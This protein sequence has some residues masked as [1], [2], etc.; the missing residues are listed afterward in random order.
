MMFKVDFARQPLLFAC[1]RI[2]L[3]GV[4]LTACK[5]GKTAP[6]EPPPPQVTVVT[7]HAKPVSL[8]SEL[9]GRTTAFETAAIEPQVSGVIRKRLFVEG[10]DVEVGQ[11]LY[12][13]DPA[14]YQALV[15]S[16][17]AAIQKARAVV[18]SEGSVANASPGGE[19][20]GWRT[21]RGAGDEGWAGRH[22][23]GAALRL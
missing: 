9:P 20:V 19:G 14:P 2:F 22:F 17:K 11:Q 10:D 13:I 18:I 8:T 21:I 23:Q 6:A 5:G 12:Q 4:S 16:E 1:V 7:I 3:L 15:D